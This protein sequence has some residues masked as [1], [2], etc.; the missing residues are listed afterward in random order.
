MASGLRAGA[1]AVVLAL[2]GAGDR[3]AGGEAIGA[4]VLGSVAGGGSGLGSSLSATVRP[5][6]VWPS[7]GG[8]GSAERALADLRGGASAEAFEPAAA[9]GTAFAAVAG[10]GV[11]MRATAVAGAGLLG[12]LTVGGIG[13]TGGSTWTAATGGGGGALGFGSGRASLPKVGARAVSGGLGWFV[14]RARFGFS[15]SLAMLGIWP[16]V[17]VRAGTAAFA[18]G[19]DCPGC[20]E[21]GEATAGAGGVVIGA[22]AAMGIDNGSEAMGSGFGGGR[23]GL[24][25]SSATLSRALGAALGWAAEMRALMGTSP[26]ASGSLKYWSPIVTDQWVNWP[27]RATS[28]VRNGFLARRSLPI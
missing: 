8:G 17:V 2:T 7:A 10:G 18:G 24:G 14:S 23:S 25:G 4:V 19:A 26:G 13:W 15:S 6:G 16:E 27:P 1:G 28:V 22:L 12:W 3:M 9:G 11:G 20:W 5:A 21:D